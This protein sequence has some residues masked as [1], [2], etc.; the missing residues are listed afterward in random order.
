MSFISRL[1]RRNRRQLPRMDR[2]AIRQELAT[3][4]A[5][6]SAREQEL[7]REKRLL[8]RDLAA[9]G[10]PS[11]RAARLQQA[12]GNREGERLGVASLLAELEDIGSAL[13]RAEIN[14]M[15]PSPALARDLSLRLGR[16]DER[17]AEMRSATGVLR[18]N[19]VAGESQATQHLE[20]I[21]DR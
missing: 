19:F 5:D 10:L 11:D 13:N 16:L 15:T 18:D 17:I 9:A 6:L 20:E 12:L 8:E 7:E 21:A 3:R 1:F 14:E 4:R 2:A